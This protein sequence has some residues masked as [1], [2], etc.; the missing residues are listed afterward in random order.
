MTGLEPSL[1]NVIDQHSLKWIFVGGKGG[2][3]KTTCSCSLATQLAAVRRNVLL[4]S[5]D[6]A[7]NISDAFNQ[8]FSKTPQKVNGFENLFA[9]EIDS[10]GAT[11]SDSM[12]GLEGLPE[13]ENNMLGAGKKLLQSM[14][15]GLPGIDEAM[16]FSEMMKLITNMDFDV[17]VFDTAPT[18]H[19]LRLLQF[20]S[21]IEQ[22]FTKILQLQSSFA[23]MISQV[24]T[25]MGAGEMNID[26]T[27]NKLKET[28]EI[29]RNMNAQ[30]K[31]PELT[32]F[33][34]V[35]IAE[36]L[37][38]YETERLIQE[39]TKQDIDTHNIIVNQL[40]YPD[41]DEKGCVQCKKCQSRH[42]IQ[43]KY[44]EQIGDL[45][46]DFHV[47]KL[48]L[49]EKE[50]RGPDAIKNFSELLR[51]PLLDTVHS[52]TLKSMSW[53]ACHGGAT[54]GSS[55]DL[56]KRCASALRDGKTALGTVMHLEQDGSFNA[57]CGSSLNWEGN[58][59]CESGVMFSD[60]RFG[61]VAGLSDIRSPSQLAAAVANNCTQ[62][63]G[64][65]APNFLAGAQASNYAK[66]LGMQLCDPKELVNQKCLRSWTKAKALTKKE[67]VGSPVKQTLD[68]VGAVEI[69]DEGNCIACSSSGG[70]IL[71]HPGRVGQSPI[72]GAGV[73]AETRS[74][75]RVAVA[76]T[77]LGEAITRCS[78]ARGVG[79]SLLDMSID[80]TPTE[81][82]SRWIDVNFTNSKWMRYFSKE[83]LIA[84]GIALL[85]QGTE[86]PE[87]IVFNNSPFL[88]IAYRTSNG[89]VKTL[90]AEPHESLSFTL[91][92]MLL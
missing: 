65:V 23:P 74:S 88:P 3:G 64:L 4:I 16:S 68:T 25:L 53:I 86:I 38:L 78:M 1:R 42:N 10:K 49:L 31:N 12:P 7:H 83:Q 79:V 18:G 59:E 9:M 58:I 32:T 30:F 5:T 87:L 84:G 34:C 28:L 29:V 70:I 73:W 60:G 57:G 75:S 62:L 47:T 37:S 48:P 51:V 92:S 24:S 20:P 11:E 15:G 90:K 91:T 89:K 50:V 22:A 41:K 69:T 72:W 55:D 17:V 21:T 52:R 2:V 56:L 63:Q 26:E 54:F 6:P 85:Q 61:G 8:Q 36:F 76:I 39:L 43:S 66:S 35:C 77:G 82:V 33:V 81:I 80:Q 27:V 14:A 46:E 44:L 19:T 40:L 13:N 71:K 67:H 45:Y